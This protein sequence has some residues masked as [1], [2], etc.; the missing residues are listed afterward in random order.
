MNTKKESPSLIGQGKSLDSAIKD[1]HFQAQMIRV[2]EAFNRKPSTMLMISI[3]TGILRAN[4]CRY[5]AKWQKREDIHLV[6]K[7]ICPISK[8]MAGYYSPDT[9]LFTQQLKLF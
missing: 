5:V 2:F 4:I 3:E 9:N 8:H 7:S 6:R 1:N